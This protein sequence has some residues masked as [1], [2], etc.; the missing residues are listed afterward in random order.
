[1]YANF[2]YVINIQSF[3]KRN[4]RTYTPQG[5]NLTSDIKQAQLAE[6]NAQETLRLAQ[7]AETNNLGFSCTKNFA[8]LMSSSSIPPAKLYTLGRHNRGL[9]FGRDIRIS[10]YRPTHSYGW[11]IA[12]SNPGEWESHGPALGYTVD[13]TGALWLT[14]SVN[15]SLA[16]H[17][18]LVMK[19]KQP[20]KVFR[21][22]AAVNDLRQILANAANYYLTGTGIL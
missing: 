12:R 9:V 17:R 2:L 10:D 1:L 19:N 7:Q 21:H 16:G 5:V 11:E 6:A 3:A 18:K 22:K 20:V 13:T 14:F 15:Y 4:R 8:A